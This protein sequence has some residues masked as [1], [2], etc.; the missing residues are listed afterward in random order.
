MSAL[1]IQSNDYLTPREVASILRISVD[2]VY[3]MFV[4]VPGVLVLGNMRLKRRPYCTLRIPRS[5]LRYF[6]SKSES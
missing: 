2:S 3:R 6:E 4:D 1:E 5:A